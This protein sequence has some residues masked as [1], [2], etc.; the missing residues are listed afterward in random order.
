ME[1]NTTDI[2]RKV[3]I[4]NFAVVLKISVALFSTRQ[5]LKNIKSC[6]QK[7]ENII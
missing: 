2:L 5:Y 7:C 6:E 1:K 3:E 4:L